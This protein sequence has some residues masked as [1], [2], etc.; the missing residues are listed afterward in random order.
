LSFKVCFEFTLLTRFRDGV[1]DGQLPHCKD[2]EVPQ[3]SSC[4]K[5]LDES[6]DPMLTFIIVQKRNN[7]R[8]FKPV[9]NNLDNAAPGTVIDSSIVRKYL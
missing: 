7:T 8:I 5:E 1:G 6:Y 3:F 4:F 2:Y 9:R